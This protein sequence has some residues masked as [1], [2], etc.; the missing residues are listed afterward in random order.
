ML[1]FIKRLHSL[2]VHYT[3]VKPKT[4]AKNPVATRTV[5]N[6]AQPSAARGHALQG[7]AAE[8]AGLGPRPD[9]SGLRGGGTP[10]LLQEQQQ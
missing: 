9:G 8:D 3:S 4:T 7:P 6:T 5:R 10:A 1:D 2:F